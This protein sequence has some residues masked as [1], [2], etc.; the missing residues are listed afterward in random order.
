M[1][2]TP[3]PFAAPE[4]LAQL[5]S[6]TKYPSIPTYHVMEHRGRLGEATIDF[7]GEA[8]YI[9]EKIDGTNARMIVF[10]GG[11]Y[12]LG[13]REELLYAR[14]D[15]IRNPTLGVVDTL[16]DTADRCAAIMAAR[17]MVDNGIVV[18][19]GEVYGGSVGKAARE[20]S[21][22][23]RTGFRLFDRVYIPRG[24]AS[25]LLSLSC[26][27]VAEWRDRGGQ[28]FSNVFDLEQT[29]AALELDIVPT[30]AITTE[31]PTDI[32]GMAAFMDAIAGY[33]AAAID[34]GGSAEGVVMRT[35]DRRVI[36]KARHEDYARTLRIAR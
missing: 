14:G 7:G 25:L 27:A 18:L 13:S 31:P 22:Q 5:N 30:R 20:Y 19:Y 8:V 17:G 26:S 24:D 1:D 4:W 12:V 33:T 36:A 6:M 32:A 34:H 16:K 35:A 29:A 10:P 28:A 11:D 9:T 2:R 21:R 23:G 15:R 3:S